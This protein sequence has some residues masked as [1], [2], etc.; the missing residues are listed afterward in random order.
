VIREAKQKDLKDILNIYNHSIL[1]G[2][3]SFEESPLT[4]QEGEEWIKSHKGDYPLF[5]L[6]KNNSVMGF[7]CLS[8][9]GKK[10]ETAY[11]LSAEIS[12]YVDKD[13]RGI[14]AG[15]QLMTEI[16]D[17]AEK[18][19]T[20]KTLISVITDGNEGSIALHEKFGFKFGGKLVN[21]AEKHN[22]ILDVLFYQR[23]FE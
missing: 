17:F 15:K 9:F 16:C 13:A 5:V 18:N 22:E 20:I 23:T 21:V 2:T 3:A 12:I 6:E 8:P 11:R 4:E 10:R 1:E 7:A 14:G 19:E